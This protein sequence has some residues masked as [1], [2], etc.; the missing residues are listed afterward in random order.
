MSADTNCKQCAEPISSDAIKCKHC[1]G[2]QNYRRHFEF[3][4]TALALLI[5]LISVATVFADRVPSISRSL[6]AEGVSLGVVARVSSASMDELVVVFKNGSDKP[7]WIRE[8]ALC[9]T[10][11]IANPEQL[12]T[13][14]HLI[15]RAATKAE[16]SGAYVVGF[17]GEAS[18]GGFFLQPSE[19]AERVYESRRIIRNTNFQMSNSVEPIR[20]GCFISVVSVD[21]R[22]GAVIPIL[23]DFSQYT[24]IRGVSE[25]DLQK[26]EL[27]AEGLWYRR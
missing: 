4:N 22:D 10:V 26:F 12:L 7:A 5:A 25:I 16:T 14:D 8:Y 3:G 20:L 9:H 27:K 1:G 2:F 6:Q 18:A 15:V 24:L 17:E 19:T 23:D 21:G 11:K 13:D